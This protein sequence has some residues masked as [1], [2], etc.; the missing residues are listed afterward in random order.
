M[1]VWDDAFLLAMS[2]AGTGISLYNNSK[3]QDLIKQGRA[4][5]NAAFETNLEAIRAEAAQSSLESIQALRKNVSSQIVINAARG[6]ASGGGSAAANINESE[7]AYNKD[8]QTRRMNLLAKENQL[9]ANNILSG[10]H[11]LTSETQMGQTLTSQIFNMIPVSS[12]AEKF[13][14]IGK[15]DKT[16]EST[17]PSAPK[18]GNK[19]G[20]GLTTV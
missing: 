16:L 5:E 10:L 19:S 3:S 17:I 18:F 13:K 6:V 20:F 15:K 8:E 1:F 11:T 12:L 7:S 4:L 2:A 14:E 9:R